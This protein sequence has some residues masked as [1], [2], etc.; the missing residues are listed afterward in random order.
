[1]VPQPVPGFDEF[2]TSRSWV[3]WV[4]LTEL[5][6]NYDYIALPQHWFLLIRLMMKS[7]NLIIRDIW[8]M[9]KKNMGKQLKQAMSE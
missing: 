9:L 1:L 7:I 5:I 8:L 2:N 4:T 6:G 3:N